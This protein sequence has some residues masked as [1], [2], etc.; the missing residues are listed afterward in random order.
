MAANCR[1][2]GRKRSGSTSGKDTTLGT[3]KKAKSSGTDRSSDVS[4]EGKAGQLRCIVS[5]KAVT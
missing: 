1:G 3:P 5:F 2:P 4:P